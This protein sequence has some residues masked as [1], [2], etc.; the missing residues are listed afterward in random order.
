MRSVILRLTNVYGPR[1][2]MRHSRQSFIAWFIRQAIEGGVIE[3]FGDGRQQRDLNHVDDVVTALL[4]AG[5]SEAAD[6][7]IFNLGGDEPLTVA[8]L[9]AELIALTGRGVARRIP[10][11]PERQL[12]DIGTFYSSFRKIEGALGWRPCTPL[13]VG[14]RRTLDF[15]E[16]HRA[17]YWTSDAGVVSDCPHPVTSVAGARGEADG[18]QAGRQPGPRPAQEPR[19]GPQ[20]PGEDAVQRP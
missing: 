11:P 5:A 12:I 1:Q 7:E 20:H 9:A 3:L 13:R 14:F 19:L 10:F 15:Y 16:R 17:H 8:E 18:R 2:L 4:L 6:G